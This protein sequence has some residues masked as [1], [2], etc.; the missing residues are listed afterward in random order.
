M[1]E[2]QASGDF[3]WYNVVEGSLCTHST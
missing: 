2:D 1:N 3:V